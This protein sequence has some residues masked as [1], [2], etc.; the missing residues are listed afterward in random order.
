M[1]QRN[2]FHRLRVVCLALVV[3]LCAFPVCGAEPDTASE[4]DALIE[5]MTIREKIGQ[6]VMA[7]F[8]TWN[9]NP[10]DENSEAVPVTQLREEIRDAISRDRFGGIIL[11]AENCPE[12]EQ[13]LELVND[14]Q[15][16]NL[17]TDSSVQ[18]PLM[19]AID[20]EGGRVARL[21]QGTRFM[22]NMAIAA[23]GDPEN[24]ETVAQRIG[25]E[26]S[27]LGINTDFSPV[28]DVNDN[29]ENPVIGTRSFS[30]DPEVVTEYGLSFLSGLKETG[31]ITS[32]KHFPG[33]GDVATDS[34]TGFPILEKSYDE[35]KECELIP[36]QAAIDAGADMV[37]TAHIQYPEIETQTYT[38]IS[39]GE[40]VFLPATLS[41]TIL[42][43]ILR[44]DMGFDGVI[45]SDALNMAAISENFDLNDIGEMA[46]EAGVDMFLMPVPVTDAVALQTL[47]EWMDALAAQV[48]NG[49]ID[50]TI[51]DASVRRIL[52]LKMEHGLLGKYDPE[53]AEEQIP[54]MEETVG[55]T[56]NHALEWE[57]MQKG[58]TLLK[59]D[60]ELLPIEAQEG[61]K[62]LV[63]YSSQDRM[64][65]AEF[66]RLRLVEEGLLPESVSV[67][68][69]TYEP[70]NEDACLSAIAEADYVI[71]VSVV[72]AIDDMNPETER[73]LKSAVLDRV[74]DAA[75]DEGKQVV[76]ISANLPYDAARYEKADAILISY[77]S[78]P[79]PELPE[80]KNTYSVNI[81]AAICG[82]FGEYS[83]S[84]ILPVNIP[85]MDEDYTFSDET[86]YERGNAA[87]RQEFDYAA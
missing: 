2:I 58:V 22:G 48:E 12:N 34:H 23:T 15:T 68:T 85:K 37:M 66:A 20:Q 18:I 79:M 71:A 59:N 33:H 40:E 70:E 6:M 16:A 55:G 81:P 9:E 43:D 49:E 61:E 44:G 28:L 51:V 39:T 10:E 64:G 32:L 84:G 82:V 60:G 24:A 69:M 62:V 83:F 4:V 52:T 75:H 11:F 63:L 25:E 86:L 67:D 3:L 76:L 29:P 35:L 73:G 50:E 72:S 65:S 7:D 30:D 54:E 74:I 45:V 53:A 87:A 46:I 47:D 27:L 57:V 8:R 56:E 41:H 26:L 42:T 14:M 31:T 19:I 13:T 5:Q 21:G 1:T 80:G 38:S 36:F 17:D 77:S 78:S